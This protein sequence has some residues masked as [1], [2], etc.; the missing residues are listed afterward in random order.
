ML[1]LELYWRGVPC[2]VELFEAPPR[3]PKEWHLAA[4]T[5]VDG[6][7][8]LLAPDGRRAR[9]RHGDGARLHL[10]DFTVVA[11]SV[12]E[13]PPAV[14][15]RF[16]D[17]PW[18]VAAAFSSLVFGFGVVCMGAYQPLSS[19]DPGT[20]VACMMGGHARPYA[21]FV[22][23]SGAGCKPPV[24]FTDALGRP[25]FMEQKPGWSRRLDRPRHGKL[26]DIDAAQVIASSEAV[27]RESIA[28]VLRAH[29]D[30]LVAC[31]EHAIRKHGPAPGILV[32]RWTVD[33]LG[34]VTDTGLEISTLRHRGIET[35]ALAVL[36]RWHF[37]AGQSGTITYPFR[38]AMAG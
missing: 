12:V 26:L 27:D 31:Q 33:R 23:C 18:P 35:C 32:L 10:G 8:E 17:W 4:V 1:K 25:R 21:A 29:R 20:R 2:G 13:R 22:G 24:S 9:V 15:N 11:T 28:M 38:F 34:N 5:R 19:E 36:E 3:A 30:E 14:R 7:Y 16:R 37:A 6:G